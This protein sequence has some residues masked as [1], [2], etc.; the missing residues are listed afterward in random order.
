MAQQINLLL[1]QCKM[2]PPHAR[3]GIPFAL[4]AQ[5]LKW[6][7]SFLQ[8]ADAWSTGKSNQIDKGAGARWI[9]VNGKIVASTQDSKIS[10]SSMHYSVVMDAV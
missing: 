10:V 7:T 1:D 2:F 5:N 4:L 3:T 9:S 8:K 6:N